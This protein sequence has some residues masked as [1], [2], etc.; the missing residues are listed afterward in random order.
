VAQRLHPLSISLLIKSYKI[1]FMPTTNR[2]ATKTKSS[3]STRQS[4][5]KTVRT[6]AKPTSTKLSKAENTES[7]GHSQLE[8]L[9]IDSLKDIYWAEKHLTKVLPK[10][11]KKATSNELKQ[12]IEEH[13]AQ[14]EEHVTRLEQVFNLCGKKPQAKKCEAMEGLT[15]EGDS[16]VEE[17]ED[18]SETRDAG[19]IMAAQKV[20]HYEI[21]TYGTLVVFAK[22]LCMNDAAN[23]LIET[24][25]EE[26]DA[27]ERLTAIAEGDINQ[28]AEQEA[29]E[30]SG[31]EEEDSEDKEE[32]EAEEEE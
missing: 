31:D 16:I 23:I 2:R 19:I 11:K 17:T 15:K 9:F 18:G 21:A 25:K 14:T 3:S 22:T 1:Y 13:L 24:L 7:N 6:A 30:E 26:K 8:K 28:S 29:D 12:A 20:E 27:D 5:A 10:M 4:R 32:V